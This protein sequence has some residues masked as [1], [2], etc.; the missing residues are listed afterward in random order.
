MRKRRLKGGKTE[1]QMASGG[2][3]GNAE[4]FEVEVGNGIILVFA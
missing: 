4:F 2:V 1:S 3:A